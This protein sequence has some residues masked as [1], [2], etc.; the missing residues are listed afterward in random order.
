MS[1]LPLRLLDP[2]LPVAVA[3]GPAVVG[4]MG[5]EAS[6]LGPGAVP[7]WENLVPPSPYLGI[8]Q[9]LTIKG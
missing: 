2:C 6:F 8:C 9:A 5:G 4:V 7:S 3:P 1:G